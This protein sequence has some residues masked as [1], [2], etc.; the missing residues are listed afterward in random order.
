M[1]NPAIQTRDLARNFGAV[2]AVDDV[3]LDV[4][5]GVVFGL[6]GPNGSGKTTLIR[7]LLG[8]I[9]PTRGHAEV[10]GHDTI[11]DGQAIRERSGVLLE[12]C[13]LYER[14]TA[15]QNLDLFA[16]FWRLD[17]GLRRTRVR[18]VLAQ[19]DLSHR[20][21][22]V[23]AGWSRGMKQKLAIARAMIHRP[24]LIF[25]DEPTGGLDPLAA[26]DLRAD[27]AR[28]VA[29]EGVTVFLTTHNMAEAERLCSHVAMIRKGRLIAAGAPA[30]L[31]GSRGSLEEAFV[32]LME[33]TS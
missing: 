9:E 4:P 26:R 25:L 32:D 7:L 1:T 23:V 28:L 12:H 20:R 30:E 22:E 16:R 15:E 13:G 14:M 8:L 11:A 31:R 5:R 29:A 17:A 21:H 6:L 2:R 33:V 3:T 24:A 10:L 19:L 27:L 18:E